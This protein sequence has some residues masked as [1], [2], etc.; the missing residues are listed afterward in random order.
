MWSD[1]RSVAGVCQAGDV[2]ATQPVSTTVST[3]Q[4]T[5]VHGSPTS[6]LDSLN[7]T[8]VLQQVKKGT[9]VSSSSPE[10]LK[11]THFPFIY[12]C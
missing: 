7:K 3:K 6:A 9:A 5:E 11:G 4:A 1:M 2:N 12:Y 10:L 8:V